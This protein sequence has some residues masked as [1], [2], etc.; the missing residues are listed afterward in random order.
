MQDRSTPATAGIHHVAALA[1]LAQRTLDFH[2]GTLGLRLVKRTVNFDDP[3]TWHLC[4]GD[5][6]GAPGT[7]LTLFPYE[8]IRPGRAGSGQFT[9]VSL[10]VPTESIGWWYQRLLAHGFKADG[11]TTRF[12]ERV[13]AF[14]DPDGI[15]YELVSAAYASAITGWAD[16][17]VPAEHAIRGIHAVV[18]HEE[19]DGLG[20]AELVTELFGFRE[21][22]R[23]GGVIRFEA[24]SGPGLGAYVD[25]RTTPGFPRGLGGGGTIHHVAFRTAD[26]VTQQT[27]R[28]EV[29]TDA[30]GFAIDEP[31]PTLGTELRLPAQY[32]SDREAI[33]SVLPELLDPARDRTPAGA[34]A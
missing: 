29:A 21:I 28:A 8:G 13:L 1:S 4:F 14:S 27:G 22:G 15:R 26:D 24:A 30:P 33:A 12:G 34:T 5:E 6:A 20:G 3:G 25:L 11:P 2:V 32:E 16:G 23:E 18:L 19:G 7:L 10:A 9:Q 31:L 17:P